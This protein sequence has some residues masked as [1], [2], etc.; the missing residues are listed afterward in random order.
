EPGTYE[1]QIKATGDG[2]A[3][4]D[5]STIYNMTVGYLSYPSVVEISE[6]MILFNEVP[7]ADSYN[8]E[9]NGFVVNTTFNS[10][11]I[12]EPGS[13]AVRLQAISSVYVD[14]PYSPIINLV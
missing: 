10:I 1:I 5:F 4:S 9:I 14:S 2:F 13:Y 3:D 7:N 11:A 12:T 8:V 6:G